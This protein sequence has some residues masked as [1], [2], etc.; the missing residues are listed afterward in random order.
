MSWQALSWNEIH[1]RTLWI[2]E[3][4]LPDSVWVTSHA[5]RILSFVA[6]FLPAFAFM[7]AAL[8]V[9]R[10]G[11]DLGWAGA[12]FINRGLLSHWQVWFALAAFTQVS[13]LYVNRL[14]AR[15]AE[16]PGQQK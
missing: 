2:P 4:M 11:A 15:G 10:L 7:E 16:I 6:V 1:A 9:W 12:F 13:S 3:R 5:I 8:G 14:V